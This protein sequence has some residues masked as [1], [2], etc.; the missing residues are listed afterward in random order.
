MGYEIDKGIELT[1]TLESM[2]VLNN[3]E[4]LTNAKFDLTKNINYYLADMEVTLNGYLL[5]IEKAKYLPTAS[6]FLNYQTQAM[7]DKFTFTASDKPYYQSA[8]WGIGLRIPVFDSFQK[9][10]SVKRSKL[11]LERIKDTKTFTEQQLKFQGATARSNYISAFEQLRAEE[12]NIKLAESI[13]NK[14]ITKFNEGI[15]NSTELMQTET[16]MIQTQGAYISSLFQLLNAKTE[17]N[18]ILLTY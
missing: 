5:K 14:T 2:W 13:R 6:A 15:A 3:H 7:R 1:D 16:Q 17:F 9:A 8:F 12:A 11:N 18:K 10:A 4:A